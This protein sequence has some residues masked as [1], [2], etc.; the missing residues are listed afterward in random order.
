MHLPA[1]NLPAYPITLIRKG[2][3]LFVFDAIRKK[4]LLCTPEE[5][6]RQHILHF[7]IREKG[8][9]KTLIQSEGALTLNTL[10]KR[11]DILAFNAQGEKILLV[12]CKAPQVKLDQRVL[13]QA[14][15]YNQVHRA[16]LMMVSNGL[17]HMFCAIDFRTMSYRFLN[18]LP[19]FAR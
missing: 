1:L 15:R 5:W 18:D 8:Y 7:L 13:D 10:G 16:P 4:Q 11:H 17:E 14:S 12:E 19:D 9:P 2:D 6:V 3:A